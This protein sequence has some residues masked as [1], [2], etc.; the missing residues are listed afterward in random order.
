M[1]NT[2]A[3]ELNTRCCGVCE[4]EDLDCVSS[5]KHSC[6]SRMDSEN[7]CSHASGHAA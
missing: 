7:F 2:T 4:D 6:N 5:M 1:V 3:A